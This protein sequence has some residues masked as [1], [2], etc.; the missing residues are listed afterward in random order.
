MAREMAHAQDTW[1]SLMVSDE[2]IEDLFEPYGVSPIWHL[3]GQSTS[4]P[5]MGS[6]VNQFY[7]AQTADEAIQTF[8]TEVVWYLY[9]EG[10][11]QYLDGGTLDLGVVRDS[12]LDATNDFELFQEVFETVAYRGFSGGAIQL[13]STLCANGESGATATVSSCA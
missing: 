2:Q 5:G 11:F 9:Y 8:P 4:A 3:D 12:L 7:G 13:I 1:N 6:S 10:A